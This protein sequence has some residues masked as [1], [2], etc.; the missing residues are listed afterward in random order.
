MGQRLSSSVAPSAAVA[1]GKIRVTV[2]DEQRR[3]LAKQS[4]VLET[5][6]ES[7]IEGKSKSTREAVSDPAGAALFEDVDASTTHSYRVVTQREGGRFSSPPF[8]LQPDRG[9]EVVV[10]TFPTT[11]RLDALSA[12]T[13]LL[14]YVVP[15]PD[16]LRT[17]ILLEVELAGTTAWRVD[18]SMLRLPSDAKAFTAEE[19]SDTARFV[20]H[21][22]EVFLEGTL[23]PGR[24]RFS[25]R[26]D[27]PS[28][29]HL[30]LPFM[31]SDE[32]SFDLALPPRVQ[33]VTI[34]A[35]PSPG[36][37]LSSPLLPPAVRDRSPSGEPV[38]VLAWE[39]SAS[40]PALQRLEFKLGALPT[41]GSLT[42]L[43]LLATVISL[44]LGVAALIRRRATALPDARR[45]QL[46]RVMLTEIERLER[47]RRAG[48]VG[49]EAHSR[50]SQR[51]LA[52]Y[53]RLLPKSP[54]R[55]AKRQRA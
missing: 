22:Q 7:V 25:G 1:A 34:A 41:R 31:Q 18:Q 49:P 37:T 19:V 29:T 3:P 12:A 40:Q 11:T 39:A 52:L 45:D 44:G 35:E 6:T 50:L 43:A 55:S 16:V 14:L 13:G 23:P 27:V 36:M 53:A 4:L 48:L 26:F 51:F 54:T 24:H 17:E 32:R 15:K 5:T 30:L 46:A 28:A 38:L 33:R 20:L 2:V 42:A 10:Q 8:N 9:F 47:A 21:G